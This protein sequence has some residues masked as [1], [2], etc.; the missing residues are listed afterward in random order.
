[1]SETNITLAI[2]TEGWQT[3]QNR[4]SEALAILSL[5]QLALCA[6]PNLRSIDEL[7]RHIIAVRAGW[8]QE[9]LGEGG[10]DFGAFSQW[11]L[12]DSPPRRANELVSDLEATWQVMQEALARFTPSDLQES[13]QKERHGKTYTFTRGWVI[14]H[15][16]EHDIHHGG[17]IAYSLGVHGLKAPDI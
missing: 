6:A 8:F 4:L 16:I 3:Y 10:E 7:A 15:V 11:D 1:M 14:W 5:D 17:E 2:I 9:A 12:P 13:I